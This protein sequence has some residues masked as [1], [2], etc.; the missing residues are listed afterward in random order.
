[1]VIR[2]EK[3]HICFVL[4]YVFLGIF[5]LSSNSSYEYL[6]SSLSSSISRPDIAVM[7]DWA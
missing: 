3:Y 2:L 7:V 1:M 5:S 4:C 6:S